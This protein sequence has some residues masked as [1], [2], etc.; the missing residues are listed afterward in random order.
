MGRGYWRGAQESSSN[1]NARFTLQLPEASLFFEQWA[2]F[3]VLGMRRKEETREPRVGSSPQSS[4]RKE[5]ATY[6]YCLGG[7]RK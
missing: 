2:S 4:H 6:C 5:L 3:K 1:A 7:A